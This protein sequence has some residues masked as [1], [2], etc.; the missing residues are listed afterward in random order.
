MY[1]DTPPQTRRNFQTKRPPR[2]RGIISGRAFLRGGLGAL[3]MDFF[4]FSDPII[5]ADATGVAIPVTRNAPISVE[6]IG[7]PPPAGSSPGVLTTAWNWIT[8]LLSPNEEAEVKQTVESFPAT[9]RQAKR[10]WALFK[11]GHQAG[12]FS[13]GE[14]EEIQAHYREFPRLFDTVKPNL[15]KFDRKA[16]SDGAAFVR[17]LGLDPLY[18]AGLGIVPIIIAG[19]LVAGAL[20]V[21]G[22]IWA[23]G[24]VKKQNNISRMIE[25]TVAGKLPADVLKAAVQDEG[26]FGS[27]GGGFGMV[28][29][30][31]AAAVIFGP[32]LLKGVR[33]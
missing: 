18:T 33:G 13:P 4:D 12:L 31:V 22:A 1:L 26:F 30:L 2:G 14:S 8:G 32:K 17:E 20:G 24:Y 27:L 9:L 10:S 3:R 21:G 15:E 29:A 16:L 19:V 11:A 6:F 7:P 25:A 23:V 5:P 28:A